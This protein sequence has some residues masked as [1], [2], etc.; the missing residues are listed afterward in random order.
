MSSAL[1]NP[2][3]AVICAFFDRFADLCGIEKQDTKQIVEWMENTDDVHPELAD[4]HMKLLRKLRKTVHAPRWERALIKFCYVS[5]S[6]QDAWEIE[7]FGYKKAS[8]AV[9]LRVLKALLEFQ[10]DLNVKFKNAINL[11]GANDLRGTPIGKD[12]YGNAYW[13]FLDDKCN[14]FIYQENSDD[15]TWR[16]V[17]NTREEFVQ[18][19]QRLKDRVPIA[20]PADEIIDE[21]DSSNSQ[22]AIPLSAVTKEEP[23]KEEEETNK[24][25]SLKIT[26][27]NPD[28][29]GV[30]E[31]VNKTEAEEETEIKQEVTSHSDSPLKITITTKG[32]KGTPKKLAESVPE[33]AP[34]KEE[35]VVVAKEA[36]PEPEVPAKKGRGRGR[37]TKSPVKT[38]PKAAQASKKQ[39]SPKNPTKRGAAARGGKR[40]RRSGRNTRNHKA[41]ESDEVGSE[42]EEETLHVRGEGSGA[43][44]EAIFE[45]SEVIEECVMYFHGEGAG[46]ESLVG[47]P[48][49]NN[50]T[51]K[52]QAKT[53]PIV[54]QSFFFGSPG[55]LKNRPMTAFGS[56]SL[57][58]FGGQ[59]TFGASSSTTTT[60]KST[61]A[62]NDDKKIDDVIDEVD[63]SSEKINLTPCKS[64]TT[65][66]PL[67]S[68]PVSKLGNTQN[69]EDIIDDDSN[70]SSKATETEDSGCPAS[71]NNL[72]TNKNDTDKVESVP[73]P[74]E[75]PSL[76][77]KL[78]DT[79]P[80]TP[81]ELPNDAPEVNNEQKTNN[82]STSQEKNSETENNL[83]ENQSEVSISDIPLPE[84]MPENNLETKK[85]TVETNNISENVKNEETLEKISEKN[86]EESSS[87][88][89]LL[90]DVQETKTEE[91][92]PEVEKPE[93]SSET[94]SEEV[95]AQNTEVTT[96]EEVEPVEKVEPVESNETPMETSVP[97]IEDSVTPEA[98]I[99]AENVPSNE[100]STSVEPTTSE[101]APEESEKTENALNDTKVNEESIVDVPEESKVD[102][103]EKPED[104]K[105]STEEP[106]V[107][108]EVE[109]TSSESTKPVSLVPYESE[110][111]SSMASVPENS[112]PEKK[113]TPLEEKVEASDSKKEEILN[114][115][116]EKVTEKEEISEKEPEKVTE[117][118]EISEKEPENVTETQELP[119]KDK[120]EEVSEEKSTKTEESTS[121]VEPE[122]VSELTKTEESLKIN[123]P[124]EQVSSEVSENLPT[125]SNSKE[126]VT[127][128][129]TTDE[130]SSNI[131]EESQEKTQK[132]NQEEPKETSAVEEVSQV[133]ESS[134][135]ITSVETPKEPEV[136]ENVTPVEN[137]PTEY[138]SE[139]IESVPEEPVSCEQVNETSEEPVSCEKVNEESIS[140]ESH[141]TESSEKLEN[142]L[143][144]EDSLI[145]E[146]ETKDI[147][148]ISNSMT[149]TEEKTVE[150]PV[151][152]TEEQPEKVEEVTKVT[153]KL[154]TSQNLSE[155]SIELPTKSDSSS[156]QALHIVESDE[157]SNV[158]T[159]IDSDLQKEDISD[160]QEEV[161]EY[162]QKKKRARTE[163]GSLKERILFRPQIDFV[164]N[165]VQQPFTSTST[166]VQIHEKAEKLEIQPEKSSA[167]HSNVSSLEE[168]DASRGSRES[169]LTK[170]PQ[171]QRPFIPFEESQNAND[172]LYASSTESSKTDVIDESINTQKYVSKREKAMQRTTFN[173]F[174]VSKLIGSN[175]EA[176]KE[177]K[178]E[179]LSVENMV[180]EKSF[181][182]PTTS[183][184]QVE[185]Q[186]TSSPYKH[187]IES[188][189]AKSPRSSPSPQ[190]EQSA[191]LDLQKHSTE[192]VSPE[193]VEVPVAETKSRGRGRRKVSNESESVPA[194]EKEKPAEVDVPAKTQPE[195]SAETEDNAI[196]ARR[197]RK[198]STPVKHENPTTEL[199][200]IKPTYVSDPSKSDVIESKRPR[201]SVSPEKVVKPPV[202]PEVVTPEKMTPKLR[203]KALAKKSI[204]QESPEKSET[205]PSP[206]KSEKS[207]EIKPAKEQE[208]AKKVEVDENVGRSTRTRHKRAANE[209][210]V[211]TQVAKEQKTSPAKTD[212]KVRG[213]KRRMSEEESRKRQSSESDNDVFDQNVE[214]SAVSESSEE[215]FIAPAGG[216]RAKMRGKQID[217][218]LRKE[219]ETKKQQEIPTTSDASEDDPAPRTRGGRQTRRSGGTT[220]SPPEKKKTE[221][222]STKIEEKPQEEPRRGKAKRRNEATNKAPTEESA[223]DVKKEEEV[224]KKEEKIEKVE[225]KE[226]EETTP[227]NSPDSKKAKIE[228][229]PV[230]KPV[231]AEAES[232][233]EPKKR[234]GRPRKGGAAVSTTTP[235]KTVNAV[236]SEIDPSNVITAENDAP[237]RQSRRIAQAKIREE[238]ERRKM[239]EIMLAQLKADNDKKKRAEAKD[240]D[241]VPRGFK[242]SSDSDNDDSN[243][244]GSRKRSRKKRKDP[245]TWKEN[246]KTSDES[247]SE[248]VEEEEDAH[249]EPDVRQAALKSDHEF[250]CESE[251]E[252]A[253]A[254]PTKRARTVKKEDQDDSDDDNPEHA[255]QKCHKTDHPEWILLCDTC[256][257]GYHCSCLKPVLFLIP[258]GD[259]FCPQ[260][261]H[262]KL[263]ETLEQKL[264]DFD[265]LTR[266]HELAEIHRQREEKLAAEKEE[267]KRVEKER[268]E[269]ERKLEEENAKLNKKSD[270]TENS[271]DGSSDSDS[272]DD[273]PLYKLRRRNQVPVTYRFNDYDDMINRAIRKDM[274]EVE[275][276]NQGSGNAGRGKDI[277]TIIEA[278][279]EE[280]RRQSMGLDENDPKPG[281]EKEPGETSESE[282]EK[283]SD[284]NEEDDDDDAP[285]RRPTKKSSG[286]K[287]KK[288]RRKLNQLDLSSDEDDPTDESFKGSSDSSDE[289]EN[290]SASSAETE[291]SLELAAYRRKANKDGRAY[292][293]RR[294]RQPRMETFINDNDSGEESDVKPTRKKK[295][296]SDSEEFELSD[297]SDEGSG[298]SEESEDVDS[299]ELCDDS[300]SDSDS[301]YRW[302]KSKKKKR[303][304]SGV[305]TQAAGKQPRKGF[306]KKR[307]VKKPEDEDKAFRAG[308]SKKKILSE[309]K[310][311]ESE[312]SDDSD[313][314][315][316][317]TR[318]RQMHYLED[319]FESSDEGIKPGVFRPDTPP[320]ER[321]AF[322]RKQE[323]IKRMLAEKNAEAAKALA[324]PTISG[325]PEV[326]IDPPMDNI[327][328]IP[329]SV[330]EN[331][332]ALDSDYHKIKPGQSVFD[333]L[334]D[335]FNP[336]E[337][338]DEELEKM[339]EEEDF[340]NH[341]LKLASDL[342]QKKLKDGESPSKKPLL[343]PDPSV[344][345]TNLV[346]LPKQVEK[347][348]KKKKEEDGEP[349]AM[350]QA[351]IANIPTEAEAKRREMP[352]KPSH[353]P[354]HPNAP[355]NVTI[356]TQGPLPGKLSPHSMHQQHAPPMPHPYQGGPPRFPPG[357]LP[358]HLY[359]QMRPGIQ[360]HPGMPGFGGPPQHL[361][362]MYPQ[363]IRAGMPSNLNPALRSLMSMPPNI[364]PSPHQ[365]HHGPGPL[366]M[367]PLMAMSQIPAGTGP[368]P[369]M[370][371]RN[372]PPTIHKDLPT[373][374]SSV[375]QATSPH[376]VHAPAQQPAPNVPPSQPPKE[377]AAPEDTSPVKKRGRR[378]KITP[379]RDDLP[380]NDPTQSIMQMKPEFKAQIPPADAAKLSVVGQPQ[381]FSL[382]QAAP[383]SVITRVIPQSPTLTNIS[384]TSPLPTSPQIYSKSP[385]HPSRGPPIPNPGAGA[386]QSP[387]AAPPKSSP[388]LPSEPG[389]LAALHSQPPNPYRHSPSGVIYHGAP[390]GARVYHDPVPIHHRIHHSGPPPAGTPPSAGSRSP[391]TR[392]GLYPGQYP[393]HHLPPHQF[394]PYPFAAGGP[395]PTS[396]NPAENRSPAHSTS[397][398]GSPYQPPGNRTPQTFVNEEDRP[399]SGGGN[400][401]GGA[402]EF[403]GLVSYFSSQH[404][405][406]A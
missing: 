66:K 355:P 340:A 397:S 300:D 239:E 317:K 29:D 108:K 319:D 374:P 287:K 25:A 44:N 40:A 189:M 351:P 336:D 58:S 404:D 68:L 154:E 15:E 398:A 386:S 401:A 266:Q 279:K 175:Q 270:S 284:K 149:A 208:V 194:E 382:T 98:E 158:S 203:A 106:T 256:D 338:D 46:Y 380:K 359:A 201:K 42:I 23:V 244:S 49:P 193:K 191:P 41:S 21:E 54:K 362:N 399:K 3:F 228:E 230:E 200:S 135:V 74:D 212:A 172:A 272:D 347:K 24:V 57:F 123:E 87:E 153:E 290:F 233:S 369:Q 195:V 81:T 358:P 316:R 112:V 10:F 337:M 80:L 361:A 307:P 248:E 31:I 226:T 257:K 28:K 297:G 18:L 129:S 152:I 250:S 236:S 395:P 180:N 262:T 241:F 367:N 184:H 305:P 303:E 169:N 234:G 79:P 219:V 151:S 352:P 298:G 334:P 223:S 211:E 276:A 251:D 292:A 75:A 254:I 177:S 104:A 55:C 370:P 259:W 186:S 390:P 185:L 388:H 206:A 258:E 196:R 393:P 192:V 392:P 62:N 139:T 205:D 403:S 313:K 263:I 30:S 348:L 267:A 83:S 60:P 12:E 291:S 6:M 121:K 107:S 119:S 136:Q 102:A 278:D 293:T 146:P 368:P 96:V 231:E 391:S 286:S 20:P 220:T 116:P 265:F 215:D 90:N 4:L 128:V 237:V 357:S 16:L 252:D 341:Q 308:I 376:V 277:S 148:E 73:T 77:E 99:E 170:E 218:S 280:K 138:I 65:Q 242:V 221:T 181:E 345:P 85:E 27:T 225:T 72:T 70:E 381:L 375:I 325:K 26:L 354:L 131:L 183:V 379:L 328:I 95:P 134:S 67:E 232:Q 165:D 217:T 163:S 8:M 110:D 115:E 339:M 302:S 268:C 245:K 356:A 396:T 168:Q 209:P 331:A 13:Y 299:E 294:R 240:K 137:Q 342:K 94:P 314:P 213:R 147:E 249:S 247:S 92:A 207:E 38:P 117:K 156:S 141:P 229:S 349:P 48:E 97:Q 335:D 343:M 235:K 384:K 275:E 50:D 93:N 47:N 283:K 190:P 155:I 301:E 61:Q 127:E 91:K 19:I 383:A 78:E 394:P 255:C 281:V 350:V 1:A 315:I 162:Q 400:N 17:A 140:V 312:D 37:K 327:S 378:K 179:S 389:R 14:I 227:I 365:R 326:K 222:V 56:S 216:K 64:F 238:A 261:Q 125:E 159:K 318:G 88:V 304:S 182:A 187:S 126:I 89:K 103:T 173:D 295:K 210:L 39:E 264:L 344:L 161:V 105:V 101:I 324:T 120:S 282:E 11:A 82:E 406:L 157:K 371:N 144:K 306:G 84:K 130:I 346:K 69:F 166:E 178:I 288:P 273:K 360:P 377:T 164:Q 333:D 253:Q 113:E 36:T 364:P 329:A 33:E 260:C 7:R 373:T 122:E 171:Q 188:M 202:E 372:V 387:S 167:E 51:N 197:G 100:E 22:P 118:E 35:P 224:A 274:E 321:E 322:I 114:E 132:L 323:E 309:K 199:I 5:T 63:K 311:E 198:K 2:D 76:S 160:K 204:S 143:P 174:S 86:N 43:E 109:N 150:N 52:E 271:S 32:R 214:P 142:E 243:A 320:E 385:P 402:G 269:A 71:T 285:I 405:D 133:E 145:E 353:M 332:K 296:K 366:A 176:A 330:I 59:A 34:V 53:T 111:S 310:K 363:N 124:E 289:E 9:K 246:A 45:C